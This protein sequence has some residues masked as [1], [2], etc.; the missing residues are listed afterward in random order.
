[1]QC[2]E[3]LKCKKQIIL[4]VVKYIKSKKILSMIVNVIAEATHILRASVYNG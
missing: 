4:N 2:G 3:V 1:V